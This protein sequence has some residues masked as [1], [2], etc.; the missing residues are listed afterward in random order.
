[1]LIFGS[2][3]KAVSIKVSVS[4][5]RPHSFCLLKTK[6]TQIFGAFFQEIQQNVSHFYTTSRSRVISNIYI[7]EK[8]LLC[9]IDYVFTI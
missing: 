8:C 5:P 1:M 7:S 3:T 2:Y 9:D 6:N 4:C